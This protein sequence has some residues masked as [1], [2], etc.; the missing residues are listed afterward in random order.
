MLN[1]IT[2]NGQTYT[3]QQLTAFCNHIINSAKENSILKDTAH[4]IIEVIEQEAFNVTTSGSTGEPKNMEIPLKAAIESAQRTETFFGYKKGD[5]ALLC[6]P[7]RYIAGKMMIIRA[8]V[9]GLNLVFAEPTSEPFKEITS[10]IAFTALTPYQFIR[11]FDWLQNTTTPP[12]NI[13]VGGA[14]LPVE[15]KQKSDT[16]QSR[17]YETF[18][19]TETCTHV[20][21]KPL[22]GPLKSQC[23]HTLK[24]I[25]AETDNRGCLNILMTI[26]G[27]KQ[28]IATNDLVEITGS[29]FKW[30]GR[31]DNIINSGGLKHIPEYIE[32][33]LSSD[34]YFNYAISAIPDE[35]LGEKIVLAISLNKPSDE[36]IVA[37]NEVINKKL[38]AY[39][40]PKG[41]VHNI[42]FPRAENGKLL[43]KDL[44]D[45]LNKVSNTY[46]VPLKIS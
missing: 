18:G 45:L 40:R 22:N 6:L 37:M 36:Q 3:G 20:A 16:L 28:K 27:E 2:I 14:P 11:S 19:M 43:R 12:Q 30:L 21:I 13:I 33:K 35:L 25:K 29:G 24:G 8:M 7:I 9:S 26:A 44:K 42:K 34:F 46:F 4:F 38:L 17:V 39:E 32:D 10:S 23:F 15:W 5:S 31:Y 41:I 1:A